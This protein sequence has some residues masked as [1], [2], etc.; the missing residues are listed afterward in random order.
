MKCKSLFY[1]K[2]KKKKNQNS[3]A[4][5]F[6]QHAKHKSFISYFPDGGLQNHFLSDNFEDCI[7]LLIDISF[8]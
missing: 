8:T 4:E 5:F 7:G 2:S 1:G 6:A 3:P